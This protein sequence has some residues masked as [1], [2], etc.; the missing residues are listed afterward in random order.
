MAAGKFEAGN[1]KQDGYWAVFDTIARQIDD[2]TQEIIPRTHESFSGRQWK[3]RN[4]MPCWM[5]E[6]DA[7]IFLKHPAFIVW[8]S[9]AEV[10]PALHLQAMERKQ[11]EMLAPNLVIAEL[12]ELTGEALLTRA[13]QKQGGNKFS[14]ETRREALIL[15][16]LDGNTA[17]MRAASPQR[18]PAISEATND[19]VD[20]DMSDE[21]DGSF[22]NMLQGA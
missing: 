8:N 13:A 19:P 7:R 9:D 21:P 20:V 11:P 5:P 6:T 2:K 14:A 15:F 22:E 17:H 16:L 12:N 4:D 18:R 1:A 3:L 10:I